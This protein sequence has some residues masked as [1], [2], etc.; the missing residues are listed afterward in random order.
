[1]ENHEQIAAR[2]TRLVRSTPQKNARR[3]LHGNDRT[4]VVRVG[5]YKGD[6]ALAKQRARGYGLTLSQFCARLFLEH[7]GARPYLSRIDRSIL[8]KRCAEL[9]R[10]SDGL[11]ESLRG[12]VETVRQ[13]LGSQRYEEIAERNGKLVEEARAPFGELLRLIDQA[14]ARTAAA[15]EGPAEKARSRGASEESRTSAQPKG[16]PVSDDFEKVRKAC[17]TAN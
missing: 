7:L 11:R 8:Q 4:G 17:R 16:A 5:L 9:D 12:V 3:R 1:M 14:E 13:G 15:R 10:A 2:G 6:D